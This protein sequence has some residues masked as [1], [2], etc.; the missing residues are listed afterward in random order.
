MDAQIPSQILTERSLR[1]SIQES[2]LRA[3]RPRLEIL[4]L[5]A[6]RRGHLSAEQL[7]ILLAKEGVPLSRASIY[8]VLRDLAQVG[9]IGP[10]SAGPGPAL[11]EYAGTPHHHFVCVH[12]GSVIDVPCRQPGRPCTLDEIPPGLQVTET[13][14]IF[15]GLC[16]GCAEDSGLGPEVG[17]S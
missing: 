15:R 5:L 7:R 12:C 13:Q 4:K 11:Y 2:G 9:L 8:N 10:A 6:D 1:S 17:A 3:T 14:I 16:A